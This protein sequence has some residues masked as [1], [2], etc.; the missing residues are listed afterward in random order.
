MFTRLLTTFDIHLVDL[1]DF[2]RVLNTFEVSPD[3][4]LVDLL[5]F[6]RVLKTF[7]IHLVD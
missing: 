4:D 3:I 6:D 5:D 7:D 2:L 1:V